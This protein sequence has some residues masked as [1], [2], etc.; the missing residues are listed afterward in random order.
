MGNWCA[1][2][3]EDKNSVLYDHYLENLLNNLNERVILLIT[4][5]DNHENEIHK[6]LDNLTLLLNYK[7]PN[8]TTLEEKIDNLTLLFNNRENIDMLNKDHRY[9]NMNSLRMINR[10]LSIETPIYSRRESETKEEYINYFIENVLIDNTEIDIYISENSATYAGQN[11]SSIKIVYKTSF[12][13]QLSMNN[14]KNRLLSKNITTL[15]RGSTDI[16]DYFINTHD[17]LNSY[18]DKLKLLFAAHTPQSCPLENETTKIHGNF[19]KEVLPDIHQ[20]TS[21]DYVTVETL[22]NDSTGVYADSERTVTPRSGTES[23]TDMEI[24]TTDISNDFQYPYQNSNKSLMMRKD[25]LVPEI[26]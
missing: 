9:S 2:E 8:H 14:I 23:D 6:K 26:H 19:L 13:T 20:N 5:V 10:E 18:I 3:N 22:Q 21:D 24:K 12:T 15:K 1:S 7:K 25:T 16:N 4:H 17:T 11:I